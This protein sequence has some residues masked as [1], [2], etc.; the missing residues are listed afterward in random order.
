MQDGIGDRVEPIRRKV[1][2]AGDEVAGG[3]VDKAV[4]R[5][6]FPDLVG[7]RLDR[8]GV[9]NIDGVGD[10]GAAV[11]GH[12]CFGALFEDRAAAAANYHFGAE[13]EKAF[14]HGSAETGASTSHQNA[15]A[16]EEVGTEHAA[17]PLFGWWRIAGHHVS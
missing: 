6:V 4:Q 10:Y 2:G 15:F 9:A 16:G 1:L 8:L 11:R 17:R 14:A 3:I 5:A 7:H 12:H 13:F